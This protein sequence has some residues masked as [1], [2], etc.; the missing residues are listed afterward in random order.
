VF[1]TSLI[2]RARSGSCP[3]D[4]WDLHFLPWLEQ[5][6]DVWRT[7]AVVY[8]LK[9]DSRGS[10]SLRSTDPRDPPLIDHGFLTERHDRDRL[11]SGVE[12]LRRLAEEAGAG[13][14]IR[15]GDVD[16]LDMYLQR[17]VRGIFHPTGTCAIGA[18][19]DPRGAV[20]GVDGLFV[21]DASIAPTIPRANT[22]LTA[23]A[24]AERV[25]DRLGS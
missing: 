23:V 7:T 14:E 9:P 11:E 10:V 19:V 18:V 15:P 22:N 5:E 4:S 8:V 16:S 2:V 21:A 24:I 12:L 20:L 6:G 25:A 17:E 3:E 1:A 13:E